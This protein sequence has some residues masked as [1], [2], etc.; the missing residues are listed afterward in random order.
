MIFRLLSLEWKQFFR[1]KSLGQSIVVKI[2]IG[3][4]AL[5]LIAS[6]LILGV[7][8]FFAL[9]DFFP[10]EDPLKIVNSYLLYWF[11][12]DLAYRFFMQKLPVMNVKPFMLMPVKRKKIIH[13]LLMKSAFSFFTFLPLFFFLPFSAVLL[14][15]GYPPVL[16]IN[17]LLA[18][19]AIELCINY[20]NF[21]INKQDKFFYTVVG[22]LLVL[23][24]LEYFGIYKVTADAGA[25]FDQLYKLPVAFLIPATGLAFL[26]YKLFQFLRRGFYLDDR[27]RTGNE[28]AKDYK[29]DWLDRFGKRSA[30]LKNDIRMILRNKRPR[31]VLL[32]SFLFLFYGL[33]FFANPR[34]AN[35]YNWIAF[36]AL[37]VTGG[38]LMTFGQLVPSW[39]SE[40]YKM[41]MSQNIPYRE[42]L[43]SKWYLMVV[44]TLLSFILSTPYLYFGW[45]VYT[46]IVGV[47]FFNVGLNSFITL[48]SGAI[49]RIPIELN[50]KA[51]AF[52][53]MQGF[54]AAQLL[55][56]IPK[57]ILPI[58]LFFV[59]NFFFGFKAGI[60][61][62]AL[63]G[64]LGLVL[65]NFFL[66]RIEKVYQKGKY[67]TIAAYAE[68][69]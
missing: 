47:T 38:F 28:E 36:G 30:F 19:L 26:Y 31:Q 9:E 23:G 40:Y 52:S 27:I 37:F 57:I 54:S 48:W 1:S 50:V 24:G 63:S 21:F 20:L 67:K 46:L 35:N 11:L 61:T 32:T 68:K 5:Y 43:E 65:K 7:A 66:N 33:L 49:N 58:L 3:F 14:F 45:E 18:V 8:S 16:V 39:D 17:W 34:Y 4:F 55:W 29:L 13:Y 51:K 15:Q 10:G 60:L 6:F 62:L 53:N 64:V 2:L 25:M 59:P 41:L 22:I 69:A 42:Y 12:I 56:T 44:G